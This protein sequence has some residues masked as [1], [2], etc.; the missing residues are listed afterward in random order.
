MSFECVSL[1]SDRRAIKSFFVRVPRPRNFL[2]LWATLKRRGSRDIIPAIPTVT[3]TR[4]ELRDHFYIYNKACLIVSRHPG[5]IMAE[6]KSVYF[7]YG[8]SSQKCKWEVYFFYW[9][10][11]LRDHWNSG[12]LVKNVIGSFD[13]LKCQRWNGR[14]R[15]SR[16]QIILRAIWC[17]V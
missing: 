11:R 3:V 10:S 7:V 14:W 13:S 1:E 16:G 9:P 15:C 4:H 12:I 17:D 8:L 2:L 6:I 5:W